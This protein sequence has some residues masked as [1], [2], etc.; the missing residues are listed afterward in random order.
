VVYKK[1]IFSP[2]VRYDFND[3]I[4]MFCKKR[5][6]TV[7]SY[8][9]DHGRED[10]TVVTRVINM[11]LSNGKVV[12]YLLYPE[13]GHSGATSDL[14]FLTARMLSL[15]RTTERA[16]SEAINK[17][18]PPGKLLFYE[19]PPPMDKIDEMIKEH[20]SPEE[21]RS[22]IQRIVEERIEKEEKSFET[23][24]GKT[25]IIILSLLIASAMALTFALLLSL[26]IGQNLVSYGLYSL[27][28]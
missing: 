1:G 2:L 3:M 9:V 28:Y 4:C 17:N 13:R 5:Y 10:R 7:S 20:R 12:E 21:I 16:I 6:E 24:V 26:F 14:I 22:E 8:D 11:V 19:F 15:E 23:P 18:L 27:Y 25:T